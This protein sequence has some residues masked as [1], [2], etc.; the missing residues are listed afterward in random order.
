MNGRI[1]H[2]PS[3]ANGPNAMLYPSQLQ[4]NIGISSTYGKTNKTYATRIPNDIG[5]YFI[6]FRPILRLRIRFFVSLIRSKL[7]PTVSM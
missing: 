4:F 5:A 6:E 2:T 3:S 7:A 1:P